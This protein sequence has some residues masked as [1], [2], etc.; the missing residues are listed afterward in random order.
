MI[1]ITYDMLKSVAMSQL[2]REDPVNDLRKLAP[3]KPNNAEL[4]ELYQRILK[5]ADFKQVKEEALE[6]ESLTLINDN[7]DTIMLYYNKLLKQ[8]SFE[9]KYDVVFRIMKEIKELK[10]IENEQMKFIVNINVEKP[11]K[12]E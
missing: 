1:D 6:V 4:A 5:H 7:V 11:E 10:A 12:P 2:Y 9:R 8:A 3:G